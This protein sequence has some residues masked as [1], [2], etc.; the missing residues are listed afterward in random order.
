M[1]FMQKLI[2]V[3]K[4]IL[5]WQDLWIFL[6]FFVISLFVWF[7]NKLSHEYTTSLRFPFEL[8]G[9]NNKEQVF[10]QTDSVLLIQFRMTGFSILKSRISAPPI[11]RLGIDEERYAKISSQRNSYFLLTGTLVDLISAQ[12]GNDSKIVAI[13]PDTIFFRISS[14]KQKR[15]PIQSQLNLRLVKEYMLKGDVVLTPD[16]TTILG[17]RSLLDSIQ[18]VQTVQKELLNVSQPMEG[19]IDI[20]P[21]KDVRVLDSEVKYNAAIV[22]FTEGT[23]KLAVQVQH[24]P[25]DVSI[26]LLPGEVELR[27]RA[28]IEDYAKVDTSQFSLAVDY[29]DIM[30]TSDKALR[31]YVISKPDKVLTVTLYPQFLEFIIQKN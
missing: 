12:V 7:L 10:Q 5:Y 13:S 2:R 1:A 23:M 31:V 28:A 8:Y 18:Y 29:E 21:I 20:Q 9:K 30:S 11:L 16:S 26:I 17:E 25:N 24:Q 4:R 6:T 27:Y 14:L 15:V 19:V 22:R 3:I